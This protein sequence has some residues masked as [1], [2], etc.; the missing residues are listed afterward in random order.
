MPTTYEPIATFTVTGSTSIIQFASIPST[1]TD[2][3]I[4]GY[5]RGTSAISTD[6]LDIWFNS[7]N[8]GGLYSTCILI[9]DGS[10]AAS[11]RWAG[12]NL[13]YRFATMPC[14]SA[15]S[16]IFG[17]FVADINNY[18]NSTTFKSLLTRY[19]YDLNGAGGTGFTVVNYRNTAAI[20]NVQI[21]FDNGQL[22]AVGSTITLYGI[23]AA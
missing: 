11:L 17:S 1:Y 16:G 12:T 8:S 2:L 14:A 9:G 21:S 18:A 13:G 19:S 5:A 6:H 4:S 22:F 23:K 15:T 20:S 7:V 10:S 3:R